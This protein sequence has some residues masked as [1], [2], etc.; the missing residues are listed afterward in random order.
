MTKLNYQ[1]KIREVADKQITN[2]WPAKRISVTDM[3]VSSIKTN[4][5]RLSN[6]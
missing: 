4:K 6:V 1:N 3:T 5:I 2:R